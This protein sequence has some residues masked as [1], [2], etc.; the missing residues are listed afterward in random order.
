MLTFLKYLPR[1]LLGFKNVSDTYKA[2]TGADRPW[3]LSRTFIFSA[4]CFISTGIT[5]VTGVKFDEETI[6]V[7]AD[8]IPTIVSGV[9]ALVGAVLSFIAQWKS[10]KNNSTK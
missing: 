8:N 3:Y 7:V 10:A 4:L 5:V 9:I 6:K 1:I 2:E